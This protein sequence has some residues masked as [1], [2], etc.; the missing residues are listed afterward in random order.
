MHL[1]TRAIRDPYFGMGFESSINTENAQYSVS[2]TLGL[3]DR[4][5]GFEVELTPPFNAVSINDGDL[6]YKQSNYIWKTIGFQVSF[7][8]I[9]ISLHF[10]II[11]N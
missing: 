8:Y 3:C 2:P 7:L 9:N 1:M 5:L 6:D 11:K 4:L 10:H